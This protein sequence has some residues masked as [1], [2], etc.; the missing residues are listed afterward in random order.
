MIGGAIGNLAD[1]LLHGAV[2]D[3]I[4]VGTFPVFNIAD[5][6]ICI[7]AGLLILEASIRPKN[8]RRR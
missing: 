7:G 8:A 3:F 1:R 4:S 5:A 6:A 2:T